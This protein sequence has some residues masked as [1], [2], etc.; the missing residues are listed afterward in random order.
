M[1]AACYA[2]APDNLII[3]VRG[4][5]VYKCD[6]T[7]GAVIISNDYQSQQ[8]GLSPASICFDTVTR[9]CFA[10]AWNCAQFDTFNAEGQRNITRIL[11]SSALP[12]LV[13]SEFATFGKIMN[14]Q[15]DAGIG[16]VKA[17]A[18][19]IYGMGATQ[20]FAGSNAPTV[21]RLGPNDTH[22]FGGEYP[23]FALAVVA[24]NQRIYF[25]SVADQ[26]V[27]WWDYGTATNGSGPVDTRERLAIEY[28][29]TQGRLYI[30]EALRFID[31]Y[32]TTGTFVL[33]LDTGRSNFNGVN[34]LRNPYTDI[35]YI[36]GG[37]DN[38]VAALNPAGNILTMKGGFDLP[39]NFV[40]TPTKTFCVQQGAVGLKEVV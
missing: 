40:F 36:A 21:Y 34:I 16:V 10:V 13:I 12:D 31:V 14:P 33:Q 24:G 5:R 11:P 26:A 6:P 30:T 3:A 4:S 29:P 20:G 15:L 27:E 2:D 19:V 7:T 1:D 17:Q 37:V 22:T 38:F 25:N 28:A 23:S 18:G 32:D 35:L 39:Y 9:R 8:L